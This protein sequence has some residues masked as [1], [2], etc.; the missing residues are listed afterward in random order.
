MRR[1][2]LLPV[3]MR[4]R[5]SEQPPSAKRSLRSRAREQKPA[6][7][8]VK[9][10]RLRR[11]RRRLSFV[12]EAVGRRLRRLN[13]AVGRIRPPLPDT[14]DHETPTKSV[15]ASVLS[16]TL[17][18]G[19]AAL[20]VSGKVV[21]IADRLPLGPDRDRWLEAAAGTDDLANSLSLNRPY[22]L[23]RDLRGAGDEAGQQIDVIGDLEDLLQLELGTDAE[24]NG[25]A[26]SP[27]PAAVPRDAPDEVADAAVDEFAEAPREPGSSPDGAPGEA[28]T[29]DDATG[30]PDTP[31][32]A[33]D[34]ALGEPGSTPGEADT[35]GEPG[36]SLAAP[37]T[38]TP[39]TA[40]ATTT[41]TVPEG[42]PA[43][44]RPVPVS[45]DTPLGVWVA[46]DSQAL[47]LGQGLRRDSPLKDLL[48]ITL[49]QR[50]STGLSRP[51]YFNWPVH[52]YAIAT[53][54]NPELVVATLG[55]NDWQSMTS[56]D[57]DLLGRG[58]DEWK[59]EWSRR[60]GVAFDV[61]Q[62]PHRQVI[63]VGL[64]PTRRDDFREGYA[65]MNR[66]AA[67]EAAARDFVT[68]VDIWDMF[69][70]DEPYRAAVAPPDDPEARPVTVR[71]Q[72]GVHLNRAGAR[73]VVEA[74]TGEIAQ[75]I[76]RISPHT[77]LG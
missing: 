32:D 15:T 35:P 27:A 68:M 57:G 1:R 58:S 13:R 30:E 11:T 38:T 29:P 69:G 24:Q 10:L 37:T 47:F 48:D 71:Q 55:S 60:L 70:G 66:L 3:L 16:A 72:D 21:E 5:T 64:P 61:L 45:A 62:A 63:W 67:A 20:L 65:L 9:R 8:P 22:D 51:G 44:V 4:W 17:C 53:S 74:I 77:L 39:A 46:G 59:Q 28:D 40:Y 2:N 33:T 42:P 7:G 34:G 41:T 52:F 54:Y 12:V 43:Y 76:D 73:W 18:L 31:D 49:D 36:E 6:I 26:R 14:A 19:V 25:D 75:I 56:E 50:H 23:L